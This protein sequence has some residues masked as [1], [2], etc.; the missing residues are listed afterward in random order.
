MYS[1][2]NEN[3]GAVYRTSMCAG[4]GL[5]GRYSPASSVV[6][7]GPDIP[8]APESPWMSD[9]YDSEVESE[10]PRRSRSRAVSSRDATL[11]RPRTSSSVP[12]M[13]SQHRLASPS[14]TNYLPFRSR[15]ILDRG[16]Y[17]WPTS[18]SSTLDRAGGRGSA[19]TLPTRDLFDIARQRR[20]R[21]D[22]V[23]DTDRLDDWINGLLSQ[24]AS[25]PVLNATPSAVESAFSP[26]CTEPQTPVTTVDTQRP[27]V[28][29]NFPRS[30]C[31][32]D[33]CQILSCSKF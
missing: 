7:V 25:R 10:N 22:D 3:V 27:V 15:N 32:N 6:S 16:P 23:E 20:R 9:F 17:N 21:G 26:Q 1:L 5:S 8:T 24:T 33:C 14:A 19:N 30:V 2:I 18:A 31:L 29:T 28:N 11:E 4:A 13:T 12:P